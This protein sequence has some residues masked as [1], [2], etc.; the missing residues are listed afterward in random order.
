M[1]KKLL[2]I[3]FSVLMFAS[4]SVQYAAAAG[5]S[6]LKVKVLENK[7]I[8]INIWAKKGKAVMYFMGNHMFKMSAKFVPIAG[9]TPDNLVQL[10]GNGFR[11]IHLNRSRKILYF[12]EGKTGE[13]ANVDI[14]EQGDKL[15]VTFEKNQ[16]ISLQIDKNAKKVVMYFKGNH[17]FF[18]SYKFLSF[19]G[20]TPNKVVELKGDGF[21]SIHLNIGRKI[22]YFREGTTG[23]F[24]KVDIAEQAEQGDKLVV[25]FEKNQ[26]ISLQINKNAKKAVMYFMGNH[27]FKMSAKFLPIAG[28]TPNNVIELK[29]NGFRSIHL[30]RSRKILYFR[31]GTTGEFA[32]VSIE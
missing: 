19:A 26:G 13:F 18:M 17:M 6:T 25:T 22:L 8:T 2:V 11:S 9:S 28:S 12:R 3:I 14:A 23:E 1:R 21:R 31:E 5:S 20:S 4:V 7:K 27:M 15:V 16:G 10:K 24:A 32:K 30:N 29:G